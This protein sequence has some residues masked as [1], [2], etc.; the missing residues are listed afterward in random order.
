MSDHPI[1]LTQYDIPSV[2]FPHV[3][4]AG[5][6]HRGSEAIVADEQAHAFGELVAIPV[7]QAA[8]AAQAVIDE[9]I[10]AR[11]TEDRCSRGECFER[12]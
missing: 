6:P 4:A 11:V 12:D 10:A 1:E 8:I 2:S 5:A 9:H 7:E 3:V